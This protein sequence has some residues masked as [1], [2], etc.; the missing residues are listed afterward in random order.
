[1][2]IGLKGLHLEGKLNGPLTFSQTF[3]LLD[4]D[5]EKKNVK[6]TF[7]A[8]SISS[9]NAACTVNCLTGKKNLVQFL[10]LTDSDVK[11]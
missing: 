7:F 11:I 1:M 10:K 8:I 4:Q 9:G 6:K 2:L 5:P 3:M